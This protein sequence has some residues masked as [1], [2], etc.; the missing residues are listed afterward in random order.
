VADA[1]SGYEL[2]WV[3][4]PPPLAPPPPPPES[5]T[6]EWVYTKKSNQTRDTYTITHKDGS[7]CSTKLSHEIN[8]SLSLTKGYSLSCERISSTDN[9]FDWKRTESGCSFKILK[10]HSIITIN[11][12]EPGDNQ[13][14]T[15]SSVLF[16]VI[17]G[18]DTVREIEIIFDANCISL[19]EIHVSID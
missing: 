5:S 2:T 7:N 14:L 12:N 3:D 9:I 19:T 13:L 4:E 6:E 11:S 16:K 10:D 8:I 1:T 18:S 15:T 17:S